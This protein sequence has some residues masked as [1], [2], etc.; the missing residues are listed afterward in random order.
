MS[1]FAAAF[2]ATFAAILQILL[3]VLVAGLLVRLK[4]ITQPQITALSTTTINVFLPCLIAATV[5]HRFD[6][7][8]M[9]LW[10]AL[11]LAGIGMSAVGLG[12]A[13]ALF[14]GRK[15]HVYPLAS[16]QN[17]GFLVLPVGLA[18]YPDQFESF[19][20]Y[21]FLFILGFNPV[22]WSV[23]KLLVTGRGGGWRGLVTT[24]LVANVA[25]VIVVLV[26][27]H[28][29]IPSPVLDAARLLGEAAVPVA[30][31]VLGAVLG[32]ISI[33]IRGAALDAVRVLAIKL[34]VLPAVT[35]TVL[36]VFDLHLSDPLLARF[37]LIEAAAAP[38][39]GIVLQVRKWGGDEQLTGS[40]MLLAYLASALTLPTWLA[41][42]DLLVGGT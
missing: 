19:A 28:Q 32:S 31:F 29:A 35:I 42:W 22:L 34:I 38:A 1:A 11:P 8:A 37:L 17:A 3:I 26:N 41:A 6:P 30:T 24:P 40:L 18:L 9:R 4:A 21:C 20:L 5:L 10:W 2:G 33:R 15:R 13:A 7:G 39:V 36:L 12:L 14:A 25:A 27:A 23:G 16:L